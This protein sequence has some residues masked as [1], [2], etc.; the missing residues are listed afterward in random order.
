MV[1]LFP[2]ILFPNM[3]YPLIQVQET[4]PTKDFEAAN[5]ILRE[6]GSPS[7]IIKEGGAI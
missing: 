2:Q 5:S 4:W 1:D 6:H 7:A 3:R